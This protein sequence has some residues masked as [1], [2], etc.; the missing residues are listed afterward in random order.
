MPIINDCQ[1]ARSEITALAKFSD[2]F[3]AYSTKYHGAKIINSQDCTVALSYK[4]KDL[5]FNATTVCFSPDAKLI[6][7]ANT[8]HLHIANM[9]DKEI[10]KSISLENEELSILAFDLSSTYVVAGNT[11]GRVLLFKY[12]SASQLARLCS[13]PLQ[14]LN[15]KF[16]ENFVSAIAFHKNLLAVSGYGGA[17]IIVDMYSGANKSV[18][19]HG[20]SRKDALYFLNE[21]TLI[22]GD[23]EGTL[24]VISLR[25]G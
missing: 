5:N 20:S 19:L 10:I 4:N 22:S 25:G 15:T 12:N 17:I 2:D 1:Q 14:R 13:F 23:N 9:R 7:F 6:A 24:Q 11:Q 18:H 21:H 8:T 16:K 3:F